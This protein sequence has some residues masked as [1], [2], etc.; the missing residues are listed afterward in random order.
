MTVIKGKVVLICPKT[1]EE[2]TLHKNCIECPC[3]KHFGLGG[4]KIYVACKYGENNDV[5]Q[6]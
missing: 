6:I 1:N 4:W 5:L 2:V 3:F